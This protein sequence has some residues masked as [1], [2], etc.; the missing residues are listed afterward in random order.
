MMDFFLLLFIALLLLLGVAALLSKITIPDIGDYVALVKLLLIASVSIFVIYILIS[1]TRFISEGII[2]FRKSR[3]QQR[4]IE[5]RIKSAR[6]HRDFMT[7][8]PI[9][10]EH[11]V[12]QLYRAEGY[13]A[14]V[15]QAQ[16]DDGI[17]INL[18]KD[19]ARIA[20]QVKRYKHGNNVGS[21]EVRDF[22][23]AYRA[24]DGGIFVTTSDFTD[25]AYAFA[26]DQPDLV[27]INGAK[28]DRLVEKHRRDS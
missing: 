12:A 5:D 10:F 8:D 21:P 6:S 16:G 2:H 17:D 20:V 4:K 7:M 23:G 19:S 11:V 22:I 9:Q 3:S 28:L 25:N 1:P 15:T 18:Y 13:D 14:R 27:L 24:C 26:K